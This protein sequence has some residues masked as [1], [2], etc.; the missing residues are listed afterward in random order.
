MNELFV[1]NIINHLLAHRRF[2]GFLSNV[3]TGKL[4]GTAED[5]NWFSGEG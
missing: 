4:A 2:Q 3:N 5:T 1:G